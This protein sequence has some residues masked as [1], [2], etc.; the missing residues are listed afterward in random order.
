[1]DQTT[2]YGHVES[3]IGTVEIGVLA[4]CVTILEFVDRPRQTAAHESHVLHMAMEQVKAY[5]ESRLKTFDLPLDMVGTP[6]QQ[7]VWQALLDVPFGRTASYQQIADA[8]GNPKA[9]RA[10]GAANGQN[11]VSIIVPCHRIIGKNGSLT[12]YGGG[13]WRKEWLLRHEGV[14]L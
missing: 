13:I 9:V 10:V 4:E 6:F 12:G 11:P 5:F 14:L 3:P 2:E 7:S 1:M 8:V